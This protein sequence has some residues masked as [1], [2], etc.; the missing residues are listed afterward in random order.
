MQNGKDKNHRVDENTK[1]SRRE[2][3]CLS[4][5]FVLCVWWPLRQADHSSRGVLPI[6]RDVSAALTLYTYNWMG[7]IGSNKHKFN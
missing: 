7:R 2:H 1:K 5:V 6:V 4:P 3:G